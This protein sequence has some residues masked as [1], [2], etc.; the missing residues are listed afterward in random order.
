MENMELVTITV[1]SI[2]YFASCMNNRVILSFSH[3]KSTALGVL[4]W[5]ERRFCTN[6]YRYIKKLKVKVNSNNDQCMSIKYST[7]PHIGMLKPS[8]VNLAQ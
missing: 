1:L 8:L 4:L 7:L 5:I 2:N 6:S 3:L